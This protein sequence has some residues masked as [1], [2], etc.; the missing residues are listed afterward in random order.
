MTS[1]RGFMRK[2]S[3][4]IAA[5]GVRIV[6]I[7]DER[8]NSIKDVETIDSNIT[9]KLIGKN[10]INVSFCPITFERPEV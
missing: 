10:P 8:I 9:S 3:A 5:T 6:A 7:A 4:N 1:S 2:S